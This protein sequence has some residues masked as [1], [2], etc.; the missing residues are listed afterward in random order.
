MMKRLLIANRGEIA[1]RIACACRELDIESVAVFSDADQHARHVE[2]ADWAVPIGP[3]PAADSYLSIERLVAAARESGADALHPGYGFLS[4]TPGLAEACEAAGLV[5]VG[6]PSSVIKRMG[7]KIEARRVMQSAGIAV[8]PGETPRD[9]SDDGVRR[10]ID[11]V[12]FPVLVKASAGGGGKGMRQVNDPADVADAVSEARREALAAFGDG[13][14]YVER[15]L[16]HPRHVEVQIFADQH[17]HVL[18]L[19]ERECSVQRRHQ[20]VVEESPSP[21]VT[22]EIRRRL[23]ETA[24]QAASAVGYRNAGTVEFLLEAESGQFYF[25]EMNTR[26]QVEHP[27]TE[28]VTG[29]DLVQAQLLVAAGAPLPWLDPVPVLRGHAI[30][31][32]VYAE[33]P[34]RDFLPQAGRVL[35]YREPRLPGVRIDAGIRQGSDVPT[36]YDALLAKAIAYGESREQARRRLAAALRDFPILGV[37]TNIPFLVDVLEHPRFI[38][39]EVDTRFLDTEADSL[40]E[41]G[42]VPVPDFV[43]AAAGSGEDESGHEGRAQWD[44]WHR[45]GAWRQG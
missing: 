41:R 39:G 29:L 16:L 10:S 11:R 5:F 33:D 17:G 28:A 37:P 15:R 40:I 2:A 31:A 27:V 1:V 23:A 32:R 42:K 36:Y 44:P 24:V 20:K 12:G 45:L 21:A 7:S 18:H 14:L 13:T 34:V 25:L 8:V 19:F 35:F 3:A 26:L 6:P 9:Q 43:L 30:E 22:P 4:E 38:A